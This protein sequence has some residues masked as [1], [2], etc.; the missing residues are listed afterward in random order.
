[1]WHKLIICLIL[2]LVMFTGCG[3]AKKPRYTAVPIT[4][5]PY[6]FG[7]DVKGLLGNERWQ[8]EKNADCPN[9][10]TYWLRN[11][12]RSSRWSG[13]I[14]I[15][16]GVDST[17]TLQGF[18]A[19]RS[20]VANKE[21]LA[22]LQDVLTEIRR[23]YGDPIDSTVVNQVLR[24]RWQDQAGGFITV[25]DLTQA[26]QWMLSSGSAKSEKDCGPTPK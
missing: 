18:T 11:P 3:K 7:T 4:G 10:T 13:Y 8:P 9:Y 1:M 21:A 6:P 15:A 19:A 22:A 23:R 5:Y 2:P 25:Y 24:R 14:S 16:V 26:G 17:G 20:F 12:P